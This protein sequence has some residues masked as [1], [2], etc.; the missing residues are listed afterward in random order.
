MLHQ[1]SYIK[2]LNQLPKF[3]Y[4]LCYRYSNISNWMANVVQI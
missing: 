4:Y 2:I 1:Q 3:W